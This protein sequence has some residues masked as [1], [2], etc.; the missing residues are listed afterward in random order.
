MVAWGSGADV[1]KISKQERAESIL[2]AELNADERIRDRAPHQSDIATAALDAIPYHAHMDDDMYRAMWWLEAAAL[3][4]DGW[5]PGDP[6][7]T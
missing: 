7:P 1:S 4:R 5:S 6:V 2:V 3:L